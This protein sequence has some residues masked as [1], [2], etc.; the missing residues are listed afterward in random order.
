MRNSSICSQSTQN[1]LV[2]DMPC[3]LGSAA[4]L[5]K[6]S[7]PLRPVRN[8]TAAPYHGC[9]IGDLRFYEQIEVELSTT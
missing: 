9:K 7:H 2:A 6:V 1:V 5:V 8:S 4:P 3:A